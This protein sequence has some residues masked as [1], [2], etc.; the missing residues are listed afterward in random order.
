M[1]GPEL[2]YDVVRT[3]IGDIILASSVKGLAAVLLPG[4]GDPETRLKKMFPGICPRWN[5]RANREA[6]GQI[7]AYLAGKR[8]SFDLDLDFGFAT[9]FQR[10][11]LRAVCRVPYGKTRSYEAIARTVG[12]PKAC[13]AVGM[14]NRLNPLPIVIPCHRI[15]GKDGSLTGYGGGIPL[16]KWLLA[17]EQGK[18][19]STITGRRK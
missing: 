6:G 12:N 2:S 8:K 4:A 18:P 5:G 1:T 17:L 9:P 15:V 11:V 16:K 3:P 7:A 10:R 19:R 13:R 14:A